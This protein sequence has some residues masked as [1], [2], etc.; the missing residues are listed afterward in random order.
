MTVAPLPYALRG[1]E[2]GERLSREFLKRYKSAFFPT[3]NLVSLA[4]QLV[5]IARA[6][7]ETT[8]PTINSFIRG[9][10]AED[11]DLPLDDF[12]PSICITG[13]AGVGKT[14]FHNA[15]SRVFASEIEIEVPGHAAVTATICW[16][17]KMVPRLTATSLTDRYLEEDGYDFPIHSGDYK[18]A[19]RKRIFCRGVSM[20]QMDETQ[21]NTMSSNANAMV[22][23]TLIRQGELGAPN[24][25]YCNYSLVH[26]LLRRPQEDH[27][28]IFGRSIV[29]LP[30]SCDSKCWISTIER[31][32]QLMPEML[33]FDAKSVAEDLHFW[34]AGLR[35]LLGEII[36]LAIL[37]AKVKNETVTIDSIRN[38]YESF[39]YTNNRTDIQLIYQQ[40][41]TNKQADK[42]RS[43]LWC[44]WPLPEGDR[45]RLEQAAKTEEERRFLTS[46]VA[47]MLTPEE[48]QI[49]KKQQQGKPKI[50]RA[51]V[52]SISAKGRKSEDLK[53]AAI[54]FSQDRD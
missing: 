21:F 40:Y 39:D 12:V 41:M 42:R 29:M 11:D 48:K 15:M 37:D 54:D 27:H 31:T 1:D 18:A 2:S 32:R 51:T 5:D 53:K 19:A 26:R 23:S 43:D 52:T 24:L 20:A 3:E 10:Y 17:L 6:H 22:A 28:R 47:S 4:L 35:R 33:C 7:S 46:A 36:R 49:N 50:T 9:S 16:S 14:S 25:F 8:Y 45:V 34:T 13:P 44:P 30:D 38:A